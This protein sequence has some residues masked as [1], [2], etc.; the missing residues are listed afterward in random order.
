M[1]L[2][3]LLNTQLQQNRIMAK[4]DLH[5]HSKYSDYPSTWAHKLYDSPESYTEPEEIY[6]Q[7]KSRGMDFVT[8]TDHDDIRGAVEL[9]AAHPDDCFISCE[10]TTYFPDDNAKIHVLV[11]GIDESQYEHIMKIR[12][13]IFVLASYVLAQGIAHSVAHAAYD[14]DG[15]LTIEHIE[16]LQLLFSNF[17]TV[18][19][20]SSQ[21]ANHL[22]ANYLDTVSPERIQELSKKYDIKP[23]YTNLAIKGRTG[24]SDDHCGILIGSGYTETLAEDKVSSVDE[25]LAAITNKRT[26]SGGLHGSFDSYALGVFKH[27]HDYQNHNSK[28]Y[29]KTKT[30]VIFEQLFTGYR[31]NWLARLKSSRSLKYL[32]HKSGDTHQ[33]LF[34]LIRDI[35]KEK[36]LDIEDKIPTLYKNATE[37]HDSLGKDVIKALTKDLE[38]GNLF[39]LFTDLSRLFPALTMAAPYIGSLRHQVVKQSIK[40]GL[41]EPLDEKP[42]KKAL[43]FSDT[44]DDL[45]G[46]SVSLKQIAKY[47][48]KLDYNVKLVT[49]RT[50]DAF[51]S[52]NLI[53]LR[54]IER[55]TLPFYEDI[56]LKFPS[57]LEAMKRIVNERP[58]EIIISTPGPIG[59]VGL[60]CGKI[61]D[62]PLKGVYH[63]DFGDQIR[64]IMNDEQ[65]GAIVDT[66]I[67]FFYKQLDT[68]YI[69]SQQYIDKLKTQGLQKERL[70][71]FPRGFDQEVYRE[72]THE[73]QLQLMP[74]LLSLKGDATLITAGRISADK[75]IDLVCDTYDELVNRVKNINLIIVGDG[76][77]LSRLR[78]RYAGNNNVLLTGRVSP[79]AMP[80][81]YSFAD[82]QI[83][84]SR[85]DTFG[86][87]V[88]EGQ[89]CG[90]PTL[91]SNSGGPQ[92]IISHCKTGEVITVDSADVWADTVTQYL[93]LKHSTPSKFN[94][95]RK[96]CRLH[97]EKKYSWSHVLDHLFGPSY[98]NNFNHNQSHALDKAV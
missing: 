33:A 21:E 54:H 59:L 76:P 72:I 39:S 2:L 25:F 49:S 96:E 9:V 51:I 7:A 42:V 56:E 79:Q 45:N 24:G 80:A 62:V 95:L 57:L 30:Y 55:Y 18:N 94:E 6:R 53:D 69:P 35:S 58:D 20:G 73:Q 29:S 93:N 88:L 87:V 3:T 89:A 84:P 71:I 97:I 41:L 52:D 34:K 38:K 40:K 36:D 48:D 14:Q 19:G 44:V 78:E 12:R 10:V 28:K 32:K 77:D 43:W 61:M 70:E 23:L 86:M 50:D 26:Q 46:V 67:N 83:F 16:K 22:I 63:T 27:L 15:K 74:E 11:Y 65:M 37:L 60:L 8:I 90:L 1:K 75:N 13:D 98:Q 81:A 4:A 31:G 66:V 5:L 17:E 85:T 92:E 47:A 91:V 82:V 64:L 68:V